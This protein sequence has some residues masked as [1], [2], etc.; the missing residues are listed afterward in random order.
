MRYSSSIELGLPDQKPSHTDESRYT[1]LMETVQKVKSPK[2][3]KFFDN[4][5]L[6]NTVGN[7]SF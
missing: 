7:T 6:R 5:Q 2:V 4:I 3:L 1:K